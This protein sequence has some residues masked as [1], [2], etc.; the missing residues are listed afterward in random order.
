MKKKLKR[1]GYKLAR[2]YIKWHDGFSYNFE[3]NGEAWL[4]HVTSHLDFKCVFDVGANVGKWTQSALE[5]YND[6][7]IHSFELVKETFETL[8]SSIISDRVTLNN[9]GVSNDNGEI[10]YKF[11]GKDSGVNTILVQSDYHDK[12]KT[13]QIRKADILKGSDYCKNQNI[14]F[15]DFL[16]I[17]TEGA[18]H[19]VLEGFEDLLKAKNVRL[20]QFEYGYT[21]GDTKFLMRDFY[22]FFA[23]QGYKAGRLRNGYVD[24]S[25][26]SYALNDFNSG[27][28]Y[29]AIRA[30]DDAL[31]ECLSQSVETKRAA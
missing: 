22:D 8:Q 18:E 17:D 12:K 4:L 11:Y 2:K 25:P 20:V 6:A 14:D 28:N 3:K 10:E 9:C 27:P 15:I 24:F 13:P 1:F 23:A 5:Q 16:K 31:F 26:W 29:V 30:D 19:L 21:N 7:H